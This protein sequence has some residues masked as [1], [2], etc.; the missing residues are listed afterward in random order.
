MRIIS[1]RALFILG[2]S[3]CRVHPYRR[4][5]WTYRLHSAAL[6][7][8]TMYSRFRSS[9]RHSRNSICTAHNTIFFMAADT[10][11]HPCDCGNNRD[12]PLRSYLNKFPA[13]KNPAVRK[14]VTLRSSSQVFMFFEVFIQT[15]IC[16][17][18]SGRLPYF[19]RASLCVKAVTEVGS[20][21]V[22]LPFLPKAN[23]TT[24]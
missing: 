13:M 22:N 21:H 19:A 11:F 17:T 9:V 2:Q 5:K 15:Y 10:V 23:E 16:P 24:I 12:Q 8:H 1:I 7:V 3:P 4:G 6:R 14:M 18:S 20:Y